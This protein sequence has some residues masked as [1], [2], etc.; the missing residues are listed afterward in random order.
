VIE[1]Q[2]LGPTRPSARGRLGA[3]LRRQSVRYLMVGA[4]NTGVGY[5]VFG[6]L[7]LVLGSRVHYT[8]L[9]VLA[10]IISTLNSF[11]AY[12]LFVF[13]VQGHFVRDL[14]R[15]A[16]VYAV[17]LGINVVALPIVV[18]VT[19]LPVFVSQGLVVA[20][21]TVGTYTAHKYFS[22]RRPAPM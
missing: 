12:R 6:C 22:F 17:A 21:T 14:A 9:L 10:W 13:R 19:K 3:V 20:C 2:R 5:L 7:L 8:I 4:Y 16:S 1:D 18:T 15:F 11:V